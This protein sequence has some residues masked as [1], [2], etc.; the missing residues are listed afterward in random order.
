MFSNG[1]QKKYILFFEWPGVLRF[2]LDNITSYKYRHNE[3]S[4]RLFDF[5]K[6]KIKSQLHGAKWTLNNEH[7][8]RC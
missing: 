6:K 5:V 7:S 8:Q 1:N 3:S 4:E 2:H